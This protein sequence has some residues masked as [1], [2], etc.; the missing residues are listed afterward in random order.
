VDVTTELDAA[1]DAETGVEATGLHRGPYQLL[2]PLS[3]EELAQ[4][5]ASI[6]LRGVEDPVVIDEDGHTLD[7]HHRRMIAERLA[8]PCETKV[9]AGLSEDEKRLYAIRRNTERR[10]LTKAQRTLVGMRAEPSFRVEAK[11][12]QGVRTDLSPDPAKSRRVWAA[13]EAARLVGLPLSTYKTYRNLIVEA[14]KEGSAI[15]VDRAIEVGD[16]DI[17]EVR[18]VALER[19]RREAAERR[20]VARRLYDPTAEEM[21]QQVVELEEKAKQAWDTHGLLGRKTEAETQ[22]TGNDLWQCPSCEAC[23][24]PT[25]TTC[26]RC[27]GVPVDQAKKAV[28]DALD[29]INAAAN[30]ETPAPKP[31]RITP[32]APYVRHRPQLEAEATT[33]LHRL[34]RSRLTW[35][36]RDDPRELAPLVVED[37]NPQSVTD[38]RDGIRLLAGWLAAFDA[39]LSG[40]LL[41]SEPERSATEADGP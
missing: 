17:A 37:W 39:A 32:P 13:E 22:A 41:G 18:E 14:R 5:E 10:Q 21:Q 29:K 33:Q 7:G 26:R 1:I 23:W 28:Q 12:R 6:R 3:A 30:A 11:A 40:T 4:L 15:A 36:T 25:D 24:P 8:I 34:R 20:E 35:Y 38:L 31:T 27:G 19:E 9:I 2:P 16:W